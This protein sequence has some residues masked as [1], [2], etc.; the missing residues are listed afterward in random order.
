MFERMIENCPYLDRN[1]ITINKFN[2]QSLAYALE[3]CDQK[4]KKFYF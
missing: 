1:P 2:F 4:I 3:R